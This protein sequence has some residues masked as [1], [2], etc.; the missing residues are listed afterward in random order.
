MS[1][2]KRVA[3]LNRIRTAIEKAELPRSLMHKLMGILG[4]SEIQLEDG[5]DSPEVNDLLV[6]ALR[7]ATL[8][9]LGQKQGQLILQTIDRFV[10]SE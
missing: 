8:H 3:Q 2:E 10:A 9:Q 1:A 6:Q 4:A 7:A 5:G